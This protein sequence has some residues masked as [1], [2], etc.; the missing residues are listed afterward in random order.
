MKPFKKRMI[1]YEK[2]V[3]IYRNLNCKRKVQYSI[4][5]GKYVVAH[6]SNIVLKDVEFTISKA[7]QLRARKSGIRNVHAY[8][9]GYIDLDTRIWLHELK[10][11][12]YDPF[13][14]NHFQTVEEKIPVVDANLGVFREDGVFVVMG[15]KKK[16]L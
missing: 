9:N 2:P 10:P 1:D 15:F 8:A 5:Q 13:K 12:K 16:I 3:S 11:I 14:M 7:G 4:K 6:T